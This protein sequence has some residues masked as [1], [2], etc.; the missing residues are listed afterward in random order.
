MSTATS[1]PTAALAVGPASGSPFQTVTVTGTA[2]GAA[3]AVKLYWDSTASVPLTTTTTT[4]AGVFV[5]AVTV[6][7]AAA[8]PHSLKAV[9]QSSGTNA[10]D[11][12]TVT[13]LVL[14]SPTSGAADSV[15]VLIGAGFG[16]S[17]TVAALWYPG[18]KLLAAATSNVTGTVEMSFTVPMSATGSYAVAGYGLTTTLSAAHS[19]TVSALARRALT[20]AVRLVARAGITQRRT[21]RRVARAG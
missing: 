15:A 10:S 6:P 3:E 2:F 4:A 18:A 5:A 13:P 11:P 20:S 1:T 21:R 14:L 19:F 9:G 8:G 7:Q 17:E 16:A 12:F